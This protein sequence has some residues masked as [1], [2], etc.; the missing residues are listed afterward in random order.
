MTE[1]SPARTSGDDHSG[2]AVPFDVDGVLVDSYAANRRIWDRWSLH[3]N[4]DPAEP[5]RAATAAGRRPA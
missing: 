4:L 2:T 5:H 1:T 3:H